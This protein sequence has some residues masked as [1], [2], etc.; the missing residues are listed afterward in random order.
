MAIL[1]FLL[2]IFFLLPIV[3]IWYYV[4][5]KRCNSTISTLPKNDPK[6]EKN[7]YVNHWYLYCLKHGIKLNPSIIGPLS[8]LQI[9][10]LPKGITPVIRTRR[11]IHK[12]RFKNLKN[13]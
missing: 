6:P 12:Q 5:V 7:E 1:I 10:R 9:K 2:T 13:D 3:L 11:R 4:I 8:S